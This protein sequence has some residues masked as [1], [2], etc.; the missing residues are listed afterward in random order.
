VLNQNQ[1]ISKIWFNTVFT[2]LISIK[3]K[4]NCLDNF[5]K[6]GKFPQFQ[7]L[8]TIFLFFE[9][10][11]KIFFIP[12]KIDFVLKLPNIELVFVKF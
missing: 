10:F 2:F 9:T 5:K 11:P 8:W 7:I 4:E 6:R 12:H 3:L 1:K